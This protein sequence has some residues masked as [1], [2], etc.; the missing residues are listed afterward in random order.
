[1]LDLLQVI[2][3]IVVIYLIFSSVVFSLVEWISSLTDRRGKLLKKTIVN[4][5]EDAPFGTSVYEHPMIRSLT[6]PDGKLPSYVPASNFAR[7]LVNTLVNRLPAEAQRQDPLE[8]FNT[9]L[10]KLP[11]GKLKTLLESMTA[12]GTQDL[13]SL[14]KSIEKWFDNSMKRASGWYKRRLNYLLVPVALA[15]TIGFNVDTIYIVRQAKDNPALRAKLNA[16]GDQ[17]L[18]D[19][20]YAAYVAGQ[21]FSDLDYYDEYVN[22][23]SIHATDTLSTGRGDQRGPAERRLSAGRDRQL[24]YLGQLLTDKAMPIGWPLGQKRSPGWIYWL[25]LGWFLTTLA[26]TAGAPFWF[27]ML[28][29]LVNLRGTGTK[30]ATKNPSA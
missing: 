14:Y 21:R 2:I 20:A 15:V 25:A 22:D 10:K 17:I 28:T 4:L 16:L 30:P 27:D 9:S 12:S 8:D 13:D 24:D 7:A 29:K 3:S 23:S 6:A 18:A 19:S 5:F 26:L 11:A 1:M